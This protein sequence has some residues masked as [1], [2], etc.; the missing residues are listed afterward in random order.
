VA[1][2]R[3]TGRRG[4]ERTARDNGIHRRGGSSGGWRRWVWGPTALVREG[5][6]GVISNLGM[7]RLRGRSPER[8]ETTAALGEIR[9]EGEASGGRRRR[10]G[11]E[12]GGEG[13]GARVGRR[14]VGDEGVDEG[15]HV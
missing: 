15:G 7:V 10:S 1:R 5:K 9:R 4:G 3:T 8:G 14:G 6:A 2:T 11:H 12:S 13:G